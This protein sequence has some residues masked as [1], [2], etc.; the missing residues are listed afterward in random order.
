MGTLSF[1]QNWG[2]LTPVVPIVGSLAALL[3]SSEGF[4]F[5]LL[6]PQNSWIDGGAAIVILTVSSFAALSLGAALN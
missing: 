6:C 1:D 4:R 2:M 5:R 3:V